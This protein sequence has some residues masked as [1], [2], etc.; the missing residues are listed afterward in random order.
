MKMKN[1]QI[2]WITLIYTQQKI[3]ELEDIWKIKKPA[4]AENKKVE[5]KKVEEDDNEEKKDEEELE[6]RHIS[7]NGEAG[8]GKSVLAQNIAYLWASKQMWNDRFE[9]LLQILLKKIANIFEKD[10]NKND[11]DI[12]EQ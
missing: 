11:D 12:E 2:Q 9:L 3:T 1:G 7:I 5:E 4:D 8:T 6:F 10:M